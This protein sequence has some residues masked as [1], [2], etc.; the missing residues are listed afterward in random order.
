LFSDFM[1]QRRFADP[2]A[3]SQSAWS[4]F[5]R[6]TVPQDDDHVSQVAL[7]HHFAMG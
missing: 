6:Q 3:P 5:P 1:D 2:A 4:M 7:R